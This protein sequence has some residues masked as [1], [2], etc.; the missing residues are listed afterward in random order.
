MQTDMAEK[1]WYDDIAGFISAQTY[2]VI[3]PT[4]GMSL[5][6]KL[7]AVVRFF[8][9]L[10]VLLALL[11]NDYRYLFLGIIAAL[12]SIVLYRFEDMQRVHAERFL[13]EQDLTVVDN[14]VCVRSTVDNPMMNPTIVDISDSKPP[15]CPLDNEEVSKTV[16]DNLASRLWKDAGDIFDRTASQRQF[17]TVS[18]TVIP[19]DQGGLASWLYG[20]SASRKEPVGA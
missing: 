16:N 5:E 10:G 4:D 11:R 7:N 6:E 2:H 12:L 8:A 9:Y 1:I 19:N 17:Y 13:H 3:L 20:A 14:R 15:A 18:S